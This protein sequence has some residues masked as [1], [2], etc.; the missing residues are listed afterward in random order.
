MHPGEIL[1]DELQ[2]LG[3]GATAFTSELHVP[4][5]RITQ[6]LEGQRSITAETAVRLG[7]CFDMDPRFWLNLQTQYELRLAEQQH[8]SAIRREVRRREDQAELVDVA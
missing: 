1:A 8:G 6:I 4:T 2:A 7:Q 5:N 3:L